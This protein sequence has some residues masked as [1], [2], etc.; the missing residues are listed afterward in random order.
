MHH[1][2]AP[3]KMTI[4]KTI[5]L[6]I[7]PRHLSSLTAILSTHQPI[8]KAMPVRL[9]LV[10]PAPA[11]A[12]G[13]LPWWSYPC[14]LSNCWGSFKFKIVS[15]VNWFKWWVALTISPFIS[16]RIIWL[17][18]CGF[19]CMR[20]SFTSWCNLNGQILWLPI[21]L[22]NITCKRRDQTCNVWLRTLLPILVFWWTTR[23]VTHISVVMSRP[24]RKGIKL[25]H[26][27]WCS[28]FY[29]ISFDTIM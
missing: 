21:T 20:H 16:D 26:P 19:R 6:S 25:L 12:S 8:S 29:P 2:I 9:I 1:P 3:A 17:P 22:D 24:S 11:I 18:P 7:L 13:C 10:H 5:K 27:I 23:Q 4:Y 28:I 15:V 14:L